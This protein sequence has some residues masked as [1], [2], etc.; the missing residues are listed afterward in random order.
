VKP[1]KLE[2]K[3]KLQELW[4]NGKTIQVIATGRQPIAAGQ[5]AWATEDLDTDQRITANARANFRA[6][7]ELTDLVMGISTEGFGEIRLPKAGEDFKQRILANMKAANDLLSLASI[8][9][10]LLANVRAADQLIDLARMVVK[11]SKE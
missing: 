3:Q 10:R 9:Q 1:W 5:Q 7:K 4:E 11:E 2:E 8:K 6:A